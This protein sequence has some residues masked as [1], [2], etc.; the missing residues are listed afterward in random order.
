MG[1]CLPPQLLGVAGNSRMD[2]SDLGGGEPLGQFGFG[3][4]GFVAPCRLPDIENYA[5]PGVSQQPDVFGQIALLV[6]K[7]EEGP[8]IRHKQNLPQGPGRNRAND[9]ATMS[10]G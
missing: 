5:H 9:F 6:P 1:F 8:D 7:G 3:E 2:V 10:F 4:A